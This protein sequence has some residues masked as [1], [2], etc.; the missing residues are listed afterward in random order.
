MIWSEYPGVA[1][2]FEAKVDRSATCHLWNAASTP[3]GYG[4]FRISQPTRRFQ[5]AHRLALERKIG[6][7][8]ERGERALHSC[9]T[10]SCVNP[11]HLRIGDQTDN[12][13]DC[14]ERG[15]FAYGPDKPLSAKLTEQKVREIIALLHVPGTNLKEIGRRYQ[16][17]ATTIAYI[18]DAKTW[19]W[20]PR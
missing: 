12:M 19:K 16:V 17:S 1:D 9:D 14:I 20:V 11:D 4:L 3:R 15:R 2:R 8:L 13:A 7:A 6:R 10:P 5:Y 18:R